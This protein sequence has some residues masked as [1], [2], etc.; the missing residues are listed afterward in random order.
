MSFVN[1]CL[2]IMLDLVCCVSQ[3]NHWIFAIGD[4]LRSFAKVAVD[5]LLILQTHKDAAATRLSAVVH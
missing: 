1:M 3:S 4:T 5:D 2:E